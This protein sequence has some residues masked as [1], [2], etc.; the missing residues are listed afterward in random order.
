[1]FGSKMSVPLRLRPLAPTSPCAYFMY[2]SPF[3]AF[4]QG[5]LL[6]RAG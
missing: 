5:F 1:M 2:Y 4:E 6:F 3:L